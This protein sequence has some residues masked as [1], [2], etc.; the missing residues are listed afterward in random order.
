MILHVPVSRGVSPL[1]GSPY[2]SAGGGERLGDMPPPTVVES[3]DLPV[4]EG[5]GTESGSC[6]QTTTVSVEG[7]VVDPPPVPVIREPSDSLPQPFVLSEGLAPIPA[8]LVARI[9]RGDFVDMAELLRDNLEAV[10]RRAPYD[11]AAESLQPKKSRREVP[12]LLS[13][14]QCF[15][16][17]VGVIASKYPARVQQLLAYQ[18][19]IVREARRCGG[20]GWQT[21][22]SMFRQQVVGQKNADWSR[23]N[24]TLY[25][26]TFLAQAGGGK[27]CPLCM[28]S[29][30]KEEDCALAQ[31]TPSHAKRSSSED[32][33]SRRE[34]LD[35]RKFPRGACFLWNQGECTHPYCRFRH[36]CVKCYGDHKVTQCRAAAAE[37]ELYKRRE[38]RPSAMAG[39]KPPRL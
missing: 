20:N 18:T 15:G 4:V 29:D 26:V 8:K 11:G 28:E 23:L 14:V 6:S 21:Y 13:W 36:V 22:D 12:D 3:L 34:K 39:D 5:G 37:R 25:A 27:N 31:S 30:H 16:T 17:C 33:S 32:G 35:G 38:G 2:P 10:R 9:L 7:S 24:S 1:L 19:L